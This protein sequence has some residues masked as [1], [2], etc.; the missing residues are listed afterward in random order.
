MAAIYKDLNFYLSC[1]LNLDVKIYIDHL[2]VSSLPSHLQSTAEDL[3]VSVRLVDGDLP[4]CSGFKASHLPYRQGSGVHWN[5]WLVLPTK[6]RD[7]PR[8][9]Q[10]IVELWGPGMVLLGGTTMRLFDGRLRLKRGIQKLTIWPSVN[11][12]T[13]AEGTE[14]SSAAVVGSVTTSS[15]SA[16]KKAFDLTLGGLPPSGVPL[17]TSDRTMHLLRLIERYE[18]ADTPKSPWLDRMAFTALYKELKS[19]SRKGTG[20]STRQRALSADAPS[21]RKPSRR[22]DGQQHA[23]T[24]ENNNDSDSISEVNNSINSPSRRPL[25]LY[26]H[27][28]S[29]D[30]PVI[31]EEW[32]YS[33]H[34]HGNSSSSHAGGSASSG[35]VVPPAILRWPH[36]GILAA[37]VQPT[38]KVPMPV[39]A[40]VLSGTQL[41]PLALLSSGATLGSLGSSTASSS[42][43]SGAA[44][45][46]ASAAAQ[47]LASA[48]DDT[49]LMGGPGGSG[50]RIPLSALVVPFWNEGETLALVHDPE[51]SDASLFNPIE[52]K[53]LRLQ[54]SQLRN[55]AAGGGSGVDK[56]L[57][58]NRNEL[59]KIQSAINAPTIESAWL[60]NSEEK[61]LLWKFRYSLTG[62]KRALVKF[63]RCV[64]WEEEDDVKEA[65][66]LLS[67]WAPIDPEDAIRLLSHDFK[68]R[69][70][71]E[72]A[73]NALRRNAS[74]EDLVLY[75][76][77]LVQALRYEPDLLEAA[78]LA[79]GSSSAAAASA[80]G[81]GGSATTAPPQR[82]RGGG[83]A[84]PAA[85]GATSQAASAAAAPVSAAEQYRL[86]PSGGYIFSPLADFL[87]DR[88]CNDGTM[89]LANFLYWYLNVEAEDIQS[90]GYG[91]IFSRIHAGLMERL[92]TYS[93]ASK[94]I[95]EGI[96]AQLQFLERLGKVVASVTSSKST[97]QGKIDKL[98]NLMAPGGPNG[99]LCRIER[100]IHIALMP[101]LLINGVVPKGCK[102]FKS[103]L[104]PTL[105]TLSVDPASNLDWTK[106]GQNAGLTIMPAAA[107]AARVVKARFASLS[108]GGNLSSLDDVP[109]TPPVSV[110]VSPGSAADLRSAIITAV[111]AS[112][113]AAQSTSTGVV[114]PP[115]ITTAVALTTS[116][117]SPSPSPSPSAAA[118]AVPTTLVASGPLS[119]TSNP[120]AT[121][122][123]IFKTGDDMRQDQLI[124]QMVRLMDSQLKRVGLDLRLTPYRV[125]ATSS[126]TGMMEMVL[127]SEPVSAVLY[128]HRGDIM[129]FF[130]AYHPKDGA[131]YGIDP[132]CMDT[133]IRSCAGYCV[134]TYILGIGDR[135]LDNIMLRR[136]GHLFHIDFG[137]I[138]GKDPK[139]L[140][141]PMRLTKEMIDGMGGPDSANYGRFKGYCCQA[142]NILRK[143]A[144]LILSLLNLMRDAGIEALAE[145]PDAVLGKMLEKFRLDLD[146]EAAEQVFLR[147]VDESV[148][149]LAP[150][151][152]EIVHRA[153]VWL[154]A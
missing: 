137:Y 19:K 24:T 91:S 4:L 6:I 148:A 40:A 95:H 33:S 5:E 22:K 61:E 15:A 60:T 103:A 94:A 10:V 28:P 116:D 32:R 75:L 117:A 51:G 150:A 134:V 45:A 153:R 37:E 21:L 77:Q 114:S 145:A 99:D 14:A 111:A 16:I 64:D 118:T 132:S 43:A 154:R 3:L 139:P 11:V 97:V 78:G 152:F 93:P 53:Y 44:S 50:S 124:I 35:V 129:S 7:L 55:A 9:A 101:S 70:V 79:A 98:N 120:C 88:A 105:I 54:R 133:Y 85:A 113:A 36:S 59:A 121:Y 125:L 100:P 92:Q 26:I 84:P 23:A 130:R 89:E 107:E 48:S 110:V 86:A 109:G 119:S 34:N 106:R 68:S 83:G 138:F 69:A 1:D 58:P 27:M 62:N 143:S 147:L 46:A 72:F 80:R 74:T 31:F 90:S 126:S 123:V 96:M 8:T 141:P 49:A 108:S 76:L 122:K 12:D 82:G 73:V 104:Y 71:R 81:K 66:S 18:L 136:D 2:D 57:K 102:I 131:E 56:N 42:S 149:A 30:S 67:K 112:V 20:E 140:P 115:A 144:N 17:I 127:E 151:F 65:V 39:Q 146:D 63:L 13:T 47:A 135:H 142:F 41:S 87:I 29:F 25:C 52:A 38:I 128:Q